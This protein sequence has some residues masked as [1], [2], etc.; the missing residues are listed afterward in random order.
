MSKAMKFPFNFRKDIHIADLKEPIG[1]E[2]KL[3]AF[4]SAFVGVTVFPNR[5]SGSSEVFFL[6]GHW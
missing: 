4:V 2:N 3:A 6:P 5:V 1:T